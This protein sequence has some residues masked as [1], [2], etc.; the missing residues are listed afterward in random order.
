M[1]FAD[2]E[3]VGDVGTVVVGG[4]KVGPATWAVA[5]VDYH[6]NLFF[7][8]VRH[9]TYVPPLQLPTRAGLLLDGTMG[10]YCR[11]PTHCRLSSPPYNCQSLL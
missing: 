1:S 3:E 6:F 7:F 10:L 9:R 11:L 8:K 2:Y 4:Y 5:F